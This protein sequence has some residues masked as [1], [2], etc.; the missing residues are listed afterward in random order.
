[1]NPK[2]PQ[3]SKQPADIAGR[4]QEPMDPAALAPHWADTL[5]T[6]AG[7]TPDFLQAETI[8]ELRRAS[9]L[10]PAADA[11][12]LETA[13]RIAG[14]PD[15]RLLARHCYRL[16]YEYAD[17]T[18]FGGWPSFQNVLGENAGVFYLLILLAAAPLIRTQHRRRNIPEEITCATCN[19][20]DAV[21]RYRATHQ[22]RWG[23][24]RRSLYWTRF[25]SNG[26][27]Y[28]LGRME[29]MLRRFKGLVEVYRHARTGATVAFAPDG[30]L[31]D[32]QGLA[33]KPADGAAPPTGTW[34][35]RLAI[36]GEHIQGCPILPQGFAV[37]EQI[38]LPAA[39]WRRALGKDDWTMDMHIPPGGGM[40]LELCGASMRQAADFFPRYF[41][42][43]PAASITCASWI[44]NTHLDGIFA[45]E[46]NLVRFQRELYLYP[47]PSTGQDGL[48]FIFGQDDPRPDT[49]PRD[50]RLQRAI[51]DFLAKGNRWRNGG[52]FF[53]AADLPHFGQ[54]WYRGPGRAAELKGWH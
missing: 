45:P 38:R 8:V 37:P 4:L 6:D 14:N 49:A 22:G 33:V 23:A 5:A 25:Y 50:T 40:T 48:V 41:P 11:P 12:L 20:R 2:P 3:Q 36:G 1:M 34:T 42:D 24:D 17:F 51:L 28:R 47:V 46:A 52:M 16:L 19:R 54:G 7:R 30:A 43:R 27:L 26:D 21:E 32:A 29:Y 15:L 53:L 39:A 10:P 35:A 18:G 44:F 31:Y 13:R 9:G